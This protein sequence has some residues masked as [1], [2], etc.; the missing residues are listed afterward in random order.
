MNEIQKFYDKLRERLSMFNEFKTEPRSIIGMIA[1]CLVITT[2]VTAVLSTFS[3]AGDE[4]SVEVAEDNEVSDEVPSEV[5]TGTS[6]VGDGQTYTYVIT[7]VN[8]N[9]I[10]GEP[11][12]GEASEDNAGIFLYAEE[13]PFEVRNGDVISVVWGEEE[14]IFEEVT[15]V[16]AKGGSVN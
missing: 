6:N 10:Y 3:G 13:V 15:L 5:S 8:G 11:V 2:V 1:L 7:D 12:P 16:Q 9:E 4:E 14:D